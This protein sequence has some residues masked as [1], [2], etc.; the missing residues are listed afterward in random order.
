LNSNP[1]AK[2]F[3]VALRQ[4]RK[5]NKFTQDQLA[6][7]SG[8]DRTYISMLELG[9]RAP[10]LKAIVSIS[11]AMNVPLSQTIEQFEVAL[12]AVETKDPI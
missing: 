3:G 5:K 12:Q 4:L 1:I 7:A 8:L 10:S 6:I 11:R 9:Q 2:A